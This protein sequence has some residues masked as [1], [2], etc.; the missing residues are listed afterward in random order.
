[1]V[2]SVTTTVFLALQTVLVI[3]LYLHHLRSKP[4][5]DIMCSAPMKR[6]RASIRMQICFGVASVFLDLLLLGLESN[7][8]TQTLQ[9]LVWS[10][11]ILASFL[12]HVFLPSPWIFR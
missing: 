6:L 8:Q 5:C 7:L 10:I 11:T 2:F 12:F 9:D 3:R 1:M 4:D